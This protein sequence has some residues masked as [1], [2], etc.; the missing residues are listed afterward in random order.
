MHHYLCRFLAGDQDQME[1]VMDVLLKKCILS[2][3]IVFYISYI[4]ISKT[5]VNVLN[6]VEVHDSAVAGID[7]TTDYWVLDTDVVCHKGSHAI[8]AGLLA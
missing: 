6:C 4:S 2:A 8:L 5:L 3:L 7:Q 1:Q